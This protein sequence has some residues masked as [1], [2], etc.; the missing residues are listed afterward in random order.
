MCSAIRA[1]S[2]LFERPLTMIPAS[3]DFLRRLFEGAHH[4]PA[5]ISERRLQN[6]RSLI[7][8]A[9]RH[10]GI[11]SSLAPYGAPLVPEWLSFISSITSPYQKSA[12][13]R[14]ARYCSTGGVSIADVSDSTIEA[15]LA[16]LI[17]ETLVKKPHLNVQTLCRTWNQVASDNA[18]HRMPPLTVPKK[19]SRAYAISKDQLSP[20]LLRDIDDYLR[21][22][23]GDDLIEGLSKP[24]R[25]RSIEAIKGNLMRYLG[26]LHHSD[27]DVSSI[28]SLEEM[29]RFETFRIALEWLWNR[30][31]HKPSQGIADIA[32]SIRCIAVKH[33]ECDEQTAELFSNLLAK[34]RPPR[35]GL[36]KKNRASMQ[37][38][39]DDAVVKRLLHITDKLWALAQKE[40]ARKKASLLAQSAVALDILTFAPM[41][42]KNLQHLRIDRHLGW[43][44]KRLRI[45]IPPEEVKNSEYLDYLL[46][47][48]TSARIADYTDNWRC[49]FYPK[50]NPHLFPGSKGRPKD[51]SALRKQISKTLLKH[52]GIR[53]TPHQFRHATAK[54][55]LDEKPGHYEVVR[56][57]LGHK[58][59]TTTYEHYAGA[60]SQSAIELFDNVILDIKGGKNTKLPQRTNMAEQA[61]IDPLN[62]FGKG[63]RR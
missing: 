33:L 57:V 27:V 7:M 38:F 4:I 54:I 22:L 11:S 43:S 5:G 14:F 23:A 9:F 30:F 29:V 42:I 21:F 56:K 48:S 28:Q 51:E 45:S 13:S 50:N 47:L 18:D 53:L 32:W 46:P 24:L 19:P 55:L 62:P 52:T 10:V 58:N 34:V 26:A 39:D 36:S 6:I 3:P 31:D 37:Q 2:R 63:D 44:N 12:I 8:A 49:L 15:Y 60:E 1:L 40:T 16:A 25:P 35:Q 17:A 41:R 59:I 61:F 20:N